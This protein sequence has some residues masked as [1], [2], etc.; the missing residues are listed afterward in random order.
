[1]TSSNFART[2]GL[3]VS[4]GILFAFAA[5]SSQSIK[6]IHP[7]SGATA[8]CSGSGF[9]IGTS[10]ADG[11]VGGCARAYEERGYVA[12]DRLRPEERADLERR[13]LLPQN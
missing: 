5:C 3:S 7:Q 6:L 9:A 12:L 10:I 13:G 4:S 8:E 11:M 1:M 2:V